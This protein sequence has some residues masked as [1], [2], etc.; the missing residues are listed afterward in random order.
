[1]GVFN[2]LSAYV[3]IPTLGIT[4]GIF[5]FIKPWPQV[6]PKKPGETETEAFERQDVLQRLKPHLQTYHD[7]PDLYEISSQRKYIPVPHQHHHIGTSLLN[8]EDHIEIDPLVIRNKSIL[9]SKELQNP[10][11]S[12][13]NDANVFANDVELTAYFHL[14]KELSDPKT[15]NI[16]KGIV[17]LL[18]DELLCVA[19]FPKLPHQ[20]GVTARLDIEH[21][22]D[23]PKDTTLVLNCK[24]KECKGR[25][26][27]IEGTLSKVEDPAARRNWFGIGKIASHIPYVSS[28]FTPSPTVYARGICLLVE[29]KW[30]KYLTWINIFD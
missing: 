9:N 22:G 1:M 14:G 8:K 29:P 3:L 16:Y 26:C 28:F 4:T 15:G 11:K 19:G 24:I 27:E 18:M 2:K 5:T 17:A 10:G 23:I 21:V 6:G 7:N 25:R 30:F 12:N 20:R 13:M